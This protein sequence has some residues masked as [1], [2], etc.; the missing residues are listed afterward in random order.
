MAGLHGGD[1]FQRFELCDLRR[2]GYLRMF[3]A[4]AEIVAAVGRFHVR[5]ARGLLGFGKGIERHLHAFVADGMKANL[6][7]GEHPLLGHFVQL[8]R[9]VTGQAR[10]LGIV[11]VGLEHRGRVRS[12]RAV[13]E[14]FQH[15]G[16]QHQIRLRMR[17]A[18]AVQL[19]DRVVKGQP[20]ADARG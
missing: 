9:I 16:V 18:L 19:F 13:H 1:D 15:A 3:D 7:A 11:G 14:S 5:L 10:V 8:G 4:Q 6:E 2:S 17:V 20:L 12:Q